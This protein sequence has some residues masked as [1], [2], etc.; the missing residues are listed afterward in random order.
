MA[1]NCC[2]WKSVSTA[3]ELQQGRILLS[4]TRGARGRAQTIKTPY[5][6]RVA[7]ARASRV[8]RHADMCVLTLMT[9]PPPSPLEIASDPSTVPRCGC[10]R[11]TLGEQDADASR[12]SSGQS[13]L[14]GHKTTRWSTSAACPFLVHLEMPRSLAFLKADPAHGL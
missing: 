12:M 3:E 14:L 11:F 2:R 6:T 4:P 8:L 7:H 9:P 10:R 5:F 13:P 1:A